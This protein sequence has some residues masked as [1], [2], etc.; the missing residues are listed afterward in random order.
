[1]SVAYAQVL[2]V[3]FSTQ[4]LQVLPVLHRH[5]NIQPRWHLLKEKHQ[6]IPIFESPSDSQLNLVAE[7]NCG[8]GAFGSSPAWALQRQTHSW[9]LLLG[10][11]AEGSLSS[12]VRDADIAFVRK[13]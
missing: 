2:A 11:A 12:S 7:P 1:M 5:H 10:T 9:D 13:A 3:C 8:G 4:V 6:P